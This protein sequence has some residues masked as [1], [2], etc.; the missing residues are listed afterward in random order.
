MGPGDDRVWPGGAAG[1]D[2]TGVGLLGW[3]VRHKI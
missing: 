1:V 2:A 3:S